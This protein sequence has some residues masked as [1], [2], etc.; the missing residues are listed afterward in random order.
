MEVM[1]HDMQR[2]LGKP[3][4]LPAADRPTQCS[5]V[6]QVIAA[7]AREDTDEGVDMAY[8]SN[9]GSPSM[10]TNEVVIGQ[11]FADDN[12]TATAPPSTIALSDSDIF[13]GTSLSTSPPIATSPPPPR[14]SLGEL[15]LDDVAERWTRSQQGMDMAGRGKEHVVRESS[16]QPGLK[17]QC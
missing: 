2:T 7:G 8:R 4:A 14:R 5:Y 1:L 12:T 16:V 11:Q 10:E 15:K 3:V 6:D 9:M 17:A 13:E